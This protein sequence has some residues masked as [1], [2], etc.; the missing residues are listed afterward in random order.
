MSYI[1]ILGVDI[2]KTT[3]HIHGMDAKGYKILQKKLTRSKFLETLAQLD[4]ETIVM[5]AC[6]GANHWARQLKRQG[7]DIKLISPQFV[8]PFVKTNKNDWKDAEAI[9]E[10]AARANMVYVE[11]LTE[12]RQDIQSIHRIRQG[13]IDT[14]TATGNRIRGLLQEYGEIAPL[15]IHKLM[16]VL[17]EIYCNESNL[18]TPRI[19]VVMMGE[20]QELLHLNKRI[21]EYDQLLEEICQQN[22]YC[23]RLRSIPGVGVINATILYVKLGSGSAFKNG[24]HFAAYLGLVPKQHS[25]GGKSNLLG[26]SKRGDQY[27]R[28]NLVHGGRSIL[29]LSKDKSDKLNTW[30]YQLSTKKKANVVA[31]ALA[32]KLARIAWAV[33]AKNEVFKKERLS[34]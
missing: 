17:P 8:K 33:V 27:V 32:N 16:E 12:D 29:K 9:C 30:C 7:R 25:S 26:I 13:L 24:R 20:F 4:C 1:K 2:A 21:K 28:K 22:E 10:A 19:R 23:Q 18:L 15:G 3:F 31:V 6:G 5:E 14:R 11:P 34:A